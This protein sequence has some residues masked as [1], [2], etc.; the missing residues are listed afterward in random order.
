[1]E[2]IVNDV[3]RMD[4]G[5]KVIFSFWV[6]CVVAFVVPLAYGIGRVLINSLT[7]NKKTMA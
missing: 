6:F 7:K 3:L 4:T 2:T 1:M 5:I